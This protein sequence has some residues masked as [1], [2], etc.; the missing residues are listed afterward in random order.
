MEKALERAG[1]KGH[2]ALRM[3]QRSIRRVVPEERV[4]SGRLLRAL[5]EGRGEEGAE[6]G[7]EPPCSSNPP[8]LKGW[9]ASVLEICRREFSDDDSKEGEGS[10]AAKC[11][12]N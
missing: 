7:D 4:G 12:R 10:R 11:S 1:D 9:A 5:A 6:E 8:I 2:A 3:V